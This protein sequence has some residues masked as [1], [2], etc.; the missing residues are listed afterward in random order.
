MTGRRVI[1]FVSDSH[2]D[3]PFS[4]EIHKLAPPA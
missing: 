4:V 1:G 2:L 3:P